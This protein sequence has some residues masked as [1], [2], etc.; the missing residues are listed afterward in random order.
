MATGD[1]HTS[2]DPKRKKGAIRL[3]RLVIP[4]HIKSTAE[5]RNT[6]GTCTRRFLENTVKMPFKYHIV[7]MSAFII[8]GEKNGQEIED[9]TI[10][11]QMRLK[12]FLFGTDEEAPGDLEVLSFAGSMKEIQEFLEADPLEAMRMSQAFR[13]QNEELNRTTGPGARNAWRYNWHE[14]TETSDARFRFRGIL[15]CKQRIVIAHA[16]TAMDMHGA[17]G[18][19]DIHLGKFLKVRNEDTIDFEITAFRHAL[20]RVKMARNFDS[21]LVLFAPISYKTLMSKDHRQ[22]YLDVVRAAPGWISEHIGI[23]VFCGPD[24]PTFD[25]IQRYATDFGRHFRYMDWQVTSHDITPSK[26]MNSGLH[27]VTFDMH[28][29]INDRVHEIETFGTHIAELRSLKIRAAITGIKTRDELLAALKVGT[30]FVSGPFITTALHA[31]LRPKQISPSELPLSDLE[32]EA[33]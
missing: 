21:P 4:E 2:N 27:S 28:H 19:D 26:F 29:I 33:A 5:L 31:P 17:P 24:A 22:K 20:E 7:N 15:H 1:I 23:M 10:S 18:F 6:I 3:V 9:Y 30:S 11:L 14:E 8:S 32:L 12:E 16:L 25:A 13:R